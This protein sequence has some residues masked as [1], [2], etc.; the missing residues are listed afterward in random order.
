MSASSKPPVTTTRFSAAE[1]D[2]LSKTADALSAYLG[3]AV[4]AEVGVS[5]EGFE[6]VTFGLI[7]NVGEQA[8]AEAIH[9]QMGGAG[10]RL[11]GNRIGFPENDETVYDCLY[12][13]AVEISDS[14]DE[15]YVKLDQTGEPAAWS[16]TLVEVLPFALA[17]DPNEIDVADE[18]DE[19]DDDEPPTLIHPASPHRH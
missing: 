13:W 11:L 10:A 1:L 7:L 4:L 9:V 18:D 19:D 3:K 17:D 8:D 16:D 2:M 5:D 15:R 12:L 14:P 6:W